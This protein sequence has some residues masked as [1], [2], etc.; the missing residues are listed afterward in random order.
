[1]PNWC[2]RTYMVRIHWTD[3]ADDAAM[4]VGWRLPSLILATLFLNI[5]FWYVPANH[6]S[7]T[8]SPAIYCFSL[9]IVTGLV[10][11]LFFLGPALSAHAAQCSL[12]QVAEASFGQIPGLA[13]RLCCAALC[14]LWIA[15]MCASLALAFLRFIFNRDFPVTEAV[16]LSG[17]LVAF[18]FVTGLQG[19]RTSAKLAFFTNKLGM[20]L[21][22]AAAIRVR[23]F[24]GDAWID[25]HGSGAMPDSVWLRVAEPLMIV[26]PM[27]LLASDFGSRSRT[28]KDVALIGVFG[29]A[30]PMAFILFAVSLIQRAAYHWR[31][32]L[33]GLA[34]ILLALWG[35]DSRWY[36]PQWMLLALITSFGVAR[37]SVRMC[38]AAL[39]PITENRKARLC[40]LAA[41]AIA[42]T[43]ISAGR[44]QV[45]DMEAAARF[46]ASAAA[47]ITADRVVKR[48][49]PQHV[50]MV[51]WGSLISFLAGWA[52]G[53]WLA[54]WAGSSYEPQLA[55]SILTSY[56]TS[57]TVALA[58]R[59]IQRSAKSLY[60]TV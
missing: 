58:G 53:Q 21:L 18:L 2:L 9:G 24:L 3:V 6:F 15:G 40:M 55:A 7:F 46:A 38:N 49:R 43:A 20:A 48:S 47:I 36:Q 29:L 50:R 28:R 11:L 33:G 34:N 4:P 39:S 44:F 59:A 8:G 54:S 35:G 37:F 17:L 45:F 5:F 52:G 12:F 1:V 16:L 27:A 30:L 31:M 13:F 25:L 51:D 22:I 26:A 23:A 41:A 14:V 10:L 60:P 42:A 56:A 19:L 32:D 57:F